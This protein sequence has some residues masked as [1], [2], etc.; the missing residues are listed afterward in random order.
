[1][2]YTAV[3]WMLLQLQNKQNI[4]RCRCRRLIYSSDVDDEE[5]E[6]NSLGTVVVVVVVVVLV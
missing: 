6:E 3:I 1:M 2:L 5:E 4:F